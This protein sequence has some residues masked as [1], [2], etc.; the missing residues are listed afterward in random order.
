MGLGSLVN[1]TNHFGI[2]MKE[3]RWERVWARATGHLM[4][5]TDHDEPNTP[6]LTQAEARISQVTRT[7]WVAVHLVTCLTVIFGVIHHW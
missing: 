1:I 7:G 2:D 4:G 3:I 5:E 6:I